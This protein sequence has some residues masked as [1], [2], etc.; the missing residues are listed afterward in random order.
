MAQDNNNN[1][2]F[3]LNVE[4]RPFVR[5]LIRTRNQETGRMNMDGGSKAI[6]L[7]LPMDFQIQDG[8]SFDTI[9]LGAITA[10]EN[11]R[12]KKASSNNELTTQKTRE[13]QAIAAAVIN[14]MSGGSL[15]GATKIGLVQGNVTSNNMSTAT[16]N[17][18]QIR[19]F[20]FNFQMMPTSQQESD[21]ITKIENTFRKF[22]YPKKLGSGFALEYP[23][24]FRIT[25]HL[26]N[27]DKNKFLP[28][29][30]DSYLTAL[31]TNYNQQGGNMFFK[32]GAPTDTA[33]G[34]SFQEQRQLTREDLYT[35]T[36]SLDDIEQVTITADSSYD[37]LNIGG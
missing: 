3:P 21:I 18:M 36:D 7:F 9:N 13:S 26:P 23:P 12:S 28:T 1:L 35:D 31:N 24:L 37:E 30:K 16:F 29:I 10:F 11:N 17:D 4:E 19:N 5:F 2:R 27:G 6:N 34:L 8:A 32:D 14:Q 22:M 25:F 15:E 33:I 20:N